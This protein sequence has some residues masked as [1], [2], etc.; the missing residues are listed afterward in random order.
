MTQ[1][2]H[3][4]AGEAKAYRLRRRREARARAI[5]AAKAHRAARRA[6]QAEEKRP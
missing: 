1:R 2:E 4:S 5:C 6:M 3:L